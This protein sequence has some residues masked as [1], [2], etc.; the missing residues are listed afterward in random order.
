MNSLEPSKVGRIGCRSI[1]SLS[2]RFKDGGRPFSTNT[3]DGK[4]ALKRW[5]RPMIKTW[6]NG[7]RSAQSIRISLRSQEGN[8]HLSRSFYWLYAILRQISKPNPPDK[9]KLPP[10]R[11][12]PVIQEICHN[13]LGAFSGFGRHT[14]NDFL[15][16][17]AIFP[18]IPSYLLCEDDATF[19]AFVAAIYAYLTSFTTPTFLNDVTSVANSTNPF[20]FNNTSND[21]YT[22][23]YILVFR[24]K[25]AKLDRDL[26]IRYCKAGLLDAEHVIGVSFSFLWTLF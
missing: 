12:R 17:Q 8:H 25:Y 18:G 11:F 16:Q 14:A 9:P 2:Q 6:R 5:R 21:K 13:S 19:D 23:H 3:T 26:Y 7:N 22:K 24:R 4:F 1:P 15:F 10:Q 20:S